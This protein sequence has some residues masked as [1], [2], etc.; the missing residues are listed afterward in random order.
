MNRTGRDTASIEAIRKASGGAPN[1]MPDRKL[2]IVIQYFVQRMRNYAHINSLA[3]VEN[4]LARIAQSNDKC[5]GENGQII[6]VLDAAR[7]IKSFQLLTHEQYADRVYGRDP[8]FPPFDLHCTY[9]L[10]G[11]IEGVN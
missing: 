6:S 9:R 8:G 3:A 5:V 10:E 2:A 7:L 1:G 11:I 4:D